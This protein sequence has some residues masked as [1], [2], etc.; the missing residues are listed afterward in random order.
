[1]KDNLQISLEGL[2]DKRLYSNAGTLY[3]ILWL[4]WSDELTLASHGPK[5]VSFW[6]SDQRN[7]VLL[8]KGLDELLILGL[9]T[10]LS[11]HDKEW[12]LITL[13]CLGDF[14]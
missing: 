13:Q 5:L 1:L 3:D 12:F 2:I 11:Q 7:A 10:I 4:F 8:A 14:M 9:V 6:G